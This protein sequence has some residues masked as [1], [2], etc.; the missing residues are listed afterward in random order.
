MYHS[1]WH[2]LPAAAILAFRQLKSQLNRQFSSSG[3]VCCV[4]LRWN[5]SGWTRRSAQ[6]RVEIPCQRQRGTFPCHAHAAPSQKRR[7]GGWQRKNRSRPCRISELRPPPK[8]ASRLARQRKYAPLR[9]SPKCYVELWWM[10]LWRCSEQL[11]TETPEVL[12]LIVKY[13][14]LLLRKENKASG[15]GLERLLYFFKEMMVWDTGSRTINSR[16]V[17]IWLIITY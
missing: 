8:F 1:V 15:S 5:A 11:Q 3:F 12:P 13:N 10:R 2:F 6:P 9:G 7:G 4:G 17:R 14:R 16:L